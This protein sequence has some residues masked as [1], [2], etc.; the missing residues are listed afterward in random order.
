[1]LLAWFKCRRNRR[2]TNKKTTYYLSNKSSTYSTNKYRVVIL[3]AIIMAINTP[4]VKAEWMYRPSFV[5]FDLV[6][7]DYD[8]ELWYANFRVTRKTSDFVLNAVKNDLL[9]EDTFMRFATSAKRRLAIT[10]YIFASTAKQLV[11]YSEFHD[12]LFVRVSGKFAAL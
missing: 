7:K 8:D 2:V 4:R 9:H 12:H 5:C 3:N 6:D 11:I 1:M 10:L